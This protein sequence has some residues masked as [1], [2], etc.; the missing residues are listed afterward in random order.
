[1]NWPN[2]LTILRVLLI[3][4]FLYFAYTDPWWAFGIFV[5]ATLTDTLDGI[6]ARRFNL[7]T[8]FGKLMDPLADKLLVTSALI[9]LTD[10]GTIPAWSVVLILGRE[11]LLTGLRGVAA[12]QGMVVA[13][14]PLGRYKTATQMVA[15]AGLLV[16]DF[17]WLH[18]L[19]W[20]AVVLTLISGLEY[21]FKLR[22]LFAETGASDQT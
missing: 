8:S 5:V 11:F 12:E 7:I 13:A 20:V 14:S 19:Y 3:P 15:L 16:F 6:L 9:V 4:P 17:A 1:M 2:R 21:G 18:G 22:G 10:L